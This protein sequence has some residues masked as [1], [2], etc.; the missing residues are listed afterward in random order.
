MNRTPGDGTVTPPLDVDRP[1][2]SKIGPQKETELKPAEAKKGLPTPVG[3]SPE[4][5]RKRRAD[6]RADVR[7][8][9]GKEKERKRKRR[10]RIAKIGAASDP[11]DEDEA[12]EPARSALLDVAHGSPPVQGVKDPGD[13]IQ[14][15]LKDDEDTQTQPVNVPVIQVNLEV[16]KPIGPSDLPDNAQSPPKEDFTPFNLMEMTPPERPRRARAPRNPTSD[17][18]KRPKENTRSV[19]RTRPSD[20]LDELFSL[21]EKGDAATK[22]E[23]QAS[24]NACS[25]GPSDTCR[26]MSDLLADMLV[27]LDVESKPILQEKA[28]AEVEMERILES[29]FQDRGPSG[30]VPPLSDDEGVEGRDQGDGKVA[31]DNKDSDTISVD[32]DVGERDL[33]FQPN[34]D[35]AEQPSKKR[36]LPWTEEKARKR[37]PRKPREEKPVSEQKPKKAKKEIVLPQ[38]ESSEESVDPELEFRNPFKIT[39][40]EGRLERKETKP[41]EEIQP[42]QHDTVASVVDLYFHS[43]T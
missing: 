12:G 26:K 41:N 17:P 19:K 29:Q 14:M 11:E 33:E 5:P 31:I 28:A 16:P 37:S 32:E 34:M 27:E 15:D 39:R 23:E 9:K 22:P 24:L 30:L 25:N 36:R 10:S 18:P 21:A 6:E 20:F 3:S 40:K 13:A 42:I 1:A 8:L 38:Q 4:V 2:R 7:D 35:Y 43:P